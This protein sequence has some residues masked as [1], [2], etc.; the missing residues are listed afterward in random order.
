M[1]KKEQNIEQAENSA[2]NIADVSTRTFLFS[3]WYAGEKFETKI[4]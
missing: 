3:G 4:K 1:D 2:L